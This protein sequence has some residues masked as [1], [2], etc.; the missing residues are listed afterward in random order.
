MAH[1][2]SQT[3][4]FLCLPDSVKPSR[5]LSSKNASAHLFI[6]CNKL[7]PAQLRKASS[8]TSSCRCE[9]G[10]AEKEAASQPEVIVDEALP[11]V[12]EDCCD[13]SDTKSTNVPRSLEAPTK[14]TNRIIALAS[15][16]AAVG[17][18]LA[19]RGGFSGAT[20]GE[21]AAAALPFE[22]ALSNGRPTVLEFYAD[23]CEV[24]KEMA[25]DVYKVE[26]QYK[27]VVLIL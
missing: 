4:Q 12:A 23:W 11:K 19:T 8:R 5:H 17:L 10:P 2:L 24:C 27:Y 1:T 22:E 26:Q 9:L 6:A 15:A 14:T 13:T 21:L 18:F 20:L 25:P 7:A 16:T 3:K